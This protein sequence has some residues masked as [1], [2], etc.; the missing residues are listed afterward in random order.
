V[1]P[2]MDEVVRKG[3]VFYV[4]HPVLLRSMLENDPVLK[5]DTELS[6]PLDAWLWQNGPEHRFLVYALGM[7]RKAG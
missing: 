7:S 3:E 5:P 1:R 2:L 6:E 4:A